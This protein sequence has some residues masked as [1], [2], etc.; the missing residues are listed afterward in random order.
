MALSDDLEKDSG[1]LEGAFFA[2]ESAGLLLELRSKSEEEQQREMLR[3]VVR[4][5]D[6]H[7]LDRLMALG[8]RPETALSIMLTP[9]VLIAWADGEM[10]DRERKAILDAAEARGVTAGRIARNLLKN[11]LARKPDAALVS[12]WTALIRRL[13]GC[14]TADERWQMRQNLLGTA[15][16]VA[17]ASGGF[18]G[19][20]SKT[21]AEER[22]VLEQLEE[23]LD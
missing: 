18:L 12:H 9:L 5:Q 1:K 21:S 8:I 16:E 6:D 15:R 2:G 19:L 20:T 17:E 10:D 11:R 4:I 23:I 13:W 7:F 3:E 22:R 14:F